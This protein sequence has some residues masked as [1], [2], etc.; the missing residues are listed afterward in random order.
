MYL[1]AARITVWA[2]S[3]LIDLLKPLK[4][5]NTL[6]FFGTRSIV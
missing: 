1:G 6:A 4:V 5:V 3:G 2:G